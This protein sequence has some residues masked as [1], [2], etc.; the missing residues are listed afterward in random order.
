MQ[1]SLHKYVPFQPC[2][3]NS[4]DSD[5]H[6][7]RRISSHSYSHESVIFLFKLR[8]VCV[9][10][11]EMH[12]TTLRQQPLKTS[13]AGAVSPLYYDRGTAGCAQWLRLLGCGT[14]S[15]LYLIGDAASRRGLSRVGYFITLNSPLNGHPPSYY[16]RVLNG[17]FPSPCELP[18][19][20][21]A[22]RNL[23]ITQK[24]QSR[25]VNIASVAKYRIF[26]RKQQRSI[27]RKKRLHK[28]RG[29]ATCMRRKIDAM[30]AVELRRPA[31]NSSNFEDSPPIVGLV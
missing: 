3:R 4:F 31:R 17:D 6:Q 27:K 23:S 1:M 12:A 22:Q 19:P 15:P 7:H 28:G 11:V 16:Y 20:S 26:S 30:I 29:L 13:T 14:R 2:G 10:S 21:F 18:A 25:S 9:F 5:H 24:H 8:R